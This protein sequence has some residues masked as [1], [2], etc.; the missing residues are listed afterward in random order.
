MFKQLLPLAKKA[1]I[2]FFVVNHINKKID[3]GFVKS[4]AD[5]V[6]LGQTESISGGRASI[7]LANNI[8]RL[9]NKGQ[10][11]EDKEYGINGNI[12]EAVFYKSRT[13]ASNVGCELIFNKKEGFD[14]IL[15]MVQFGLN[16]GFIKKKG[17][18]Y[19]IEGLEDFTFSKKTAREVIGEHPEMVNAL[20][21]L[22]LPYLRTYLSS[23]PYKGEE[24]EEERAE[25]YINIMNLLSA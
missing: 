16:N 22:A 23:E 7:Y 15:T 1:N 19:C 18:K 2:I 4:A 20:Y 25:A 17:T 3:A 6:G 12:I 14:P 9:K 24:T 11:K 13:N 10:L 5:I 8:L 21:D